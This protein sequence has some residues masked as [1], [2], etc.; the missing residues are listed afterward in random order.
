MK[1]NQNGVNSPNPG[2]VKFVYRTGPLEESFENDNCCIL[3]AKG[4]REHVCDLL[5]GGD[6]AFRIRENKYQL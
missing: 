3:L 2:N 5:E 6:D 4:I 1:L